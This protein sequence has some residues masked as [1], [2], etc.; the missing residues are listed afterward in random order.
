M[1]RCIYLEDN[2]ICIDSGTDIIYI[3]RD[4]IESPINL[5]EIIL[6]QKEDKSESNN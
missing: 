4:E 5:D 3:P 2:N 1:T 6:K